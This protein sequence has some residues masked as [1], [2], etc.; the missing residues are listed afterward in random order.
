MEWS[1]VGGG[2]G[3]ANGQTS[4]TGGQGGGAGELVIRLPLNVTPGETLTI[5]IGAGGPG[6]SSVVTAGGDTII[7]GSFGTYKAKGADNAGN[8]GGANPGLKAAPSSTIGGIGGYETPCHT[9]GSAGGTASQTS[10]PGGPGG[11]SGG[12][13]SGGAGGTGSSGGGG[14]GAATIFGPGGAGGNTSNGAGSAPASTAYGAGGGGGGSTSGTGGAGRDGWS[15][16]AWNA[17]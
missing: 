7:S 6:G 17:P 5:T 9:G 10:S 16:L 11:G 13:T 15:M 3:G 14:G 2:A 1:S 12:L 4:S 8:G